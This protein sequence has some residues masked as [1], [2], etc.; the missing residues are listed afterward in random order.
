MLERKLSRE[1]IVTRILESAPDRGN[2]VAHIGSGD[3]PRLLFMSHL[4]VVPVDDAEYWRY[5]PFSGTVAEGA[6]HGR[7]AA[8]CKGLAAACAMALAILSA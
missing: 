5:P 4:D 8:D 1:G 7:G 6:I 2:L 3:R